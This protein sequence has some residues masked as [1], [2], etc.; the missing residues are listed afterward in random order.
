MDYVNISGTSI[1][2]VSVVNNAKLLCSMALNSH[3][4]ENMV[5]KLE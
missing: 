5:L 2:S 1:I 3:R 4:L